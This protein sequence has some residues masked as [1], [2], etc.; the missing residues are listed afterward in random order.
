MVA[1]SSATT[2]PACGASSSSVPRDWRSGDTIFRADG[3]P[4]TMRG[5]N[6]RDYTSHNAEVQ[7]ERVVNAFTY[8]VCCLRTFRNG[9]VSVLGLD[10][11]KKQPS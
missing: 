5:S 6:G 2:P 1:T 11:H 9:C 7:I 3:K 4:W 10:V 8:D